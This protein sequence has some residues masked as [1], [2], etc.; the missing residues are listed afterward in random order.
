MYVNREERTANQRQLLESYLILN[1]FRMMPSDKPT[2]LRLRQAGKDQDFY[3]SVDP[4]WLQLITDATVQ[5][6][7]DTLQLIPFLRKNGSAWLG[8]TATGEEVITHMER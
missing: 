7:L 8:L 2:T 6:R 4:Q 5:S 3:L 1:D